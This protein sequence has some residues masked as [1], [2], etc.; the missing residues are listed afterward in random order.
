MVY[1]G[2][3]L[4]IPVDGRYFHNWIWTVRMRFWIMNSDMSSVIITVITGVRVVL[5]TRVEDGGCIVTIPGLLD[6]R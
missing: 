3:V 2:K 5:L 6:R 1:V 4:V